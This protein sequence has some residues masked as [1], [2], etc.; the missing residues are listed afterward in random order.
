MNYFTNPDQI[1][2]NIPNVLV[3]DKHLN[4]FF[5]IQFCFTV[6]FD[7]K[8]NKEIKTRISKSNSAFRIFHK[9]LWDT[10]DD[11]PRNKVDVL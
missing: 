1:P 11:F 8:T 2:D 4:T 3:N 9:C 10:H 5:F 6:L 7:T